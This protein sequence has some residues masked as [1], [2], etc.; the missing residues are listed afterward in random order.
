MKEKNTDALDLAKE[1]RLAIKK[2]LEK[3]KKGATPKFCEMIKT[4]AGY[5]K[6]ESMIIDFSIKN[7]IS[8]SAS[9]AQLESELE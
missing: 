7:Q 9:I 3:C 2:E 8:V 6:A 1:L 4:K 5:L